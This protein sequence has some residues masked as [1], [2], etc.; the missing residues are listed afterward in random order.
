[1]AWRS[2]GAT[3]AELVENLWRNKLITQPLV[4]SAFLKVDR[5]HYAPS[6]AYE[7]SPQ[8][9]GHHATISAPHM[10]AHAVET[11]LPFLLPNPDNGHQST[12]DS[13]AS[14]IGQAG[15]PRRV[16]DIGSGSGYLTHVLAELAGETGVVVGLEHIPA[17]RDLGERN[18][19]KSAEGRAL[20]AS[21]RVRFRVGDG[22]K[23]WEE[24]SP[25]DAQPGVGGAAAP[26]VA[27]EHERKD[28]AGGWDAIHVG[29]AAAVLHEDLVRQLRCPG[30][31]FI[32][33]A[34][35]SS[36]EQYIWT[37]DKD[38][39][40]GVKKKK[41]FGVRYVPLTDAPK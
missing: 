9:I 33:V 19:G 16:L 14:V 7:D 10:H 34:A 29:A 15:R 12:A 39:H 6:M 41:L 1:M 22:R 32:P 13:A 24:P 20:L 28:E 27:R 18:V 31:M 8:P 37:V 5:A 26:D 25:G 4:K 38:E 36:S 11:L 40:G 17:L 35:E 3:N 2:S 30:R 21:G 23:G